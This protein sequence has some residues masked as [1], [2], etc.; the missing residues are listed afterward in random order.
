MKKILFF[1]RK[2]FPLWCAAVICG[3]AFC[4]PWISVPST[5]AG[6]KMP[7][8][9]LSLH[10]RAGN[11][12]IFYSFPRMLKHLGKQKNIVCY[13]GIDLP[14]AIIEAYGQPINRFFL[15]IE[16]LNLY[17]LL[18][19]TYPVWIF[20]CAYSMAGKR[21]WKYMKYVLV[22]VCS[23]VLITQVFVVGFVDI[24]PYPVGVYLDYGY[25]LGA[26][27][28]FVAIMYALMLL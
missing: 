18:V 10:A 20:V 27:S 13:K 15:S 9:A 6:F 23:A 11:R 21:A 5:N 7:R 2:T 1:R 19:Y 24:A 28:Y 26:V 25:W 12:L 4:L 17:A 22:A 16:N 3:T 8:V 14:E